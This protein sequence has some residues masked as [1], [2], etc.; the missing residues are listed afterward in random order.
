MKRDLI[1]LWFEISEKGVETDPKNIE[2]IKNMPAP[3]TVRQVRIFN[4][5]TNYYRKFIKN[6]ATIARPL[7]NLLKKDTPFK[8]TEETYKAF[9]LQ[10]QKLYSAPALVFP[11]LEK[12]FSLHTDSSGYAIG[13]CLCQGPKGKE[14]PV[15]YISRTLTAIE[16]KYFTYDKEFF[17]IYWLIDHL[18]GYL[19]KHFTDY[20]DHRPLS[21]CEKS[22]TNKWVLKW[23]HEISDLDFTITYLKGKTKAMPGSI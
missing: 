15:C 18:R 5:L 12:E 3:K 17:A 22:E 11:D 23:R 9:D 1:Y 20:C 4:G 16:R 10:K 14:N 19:Y 6:Y 2:A 8:W 13:C 21:S 7:T